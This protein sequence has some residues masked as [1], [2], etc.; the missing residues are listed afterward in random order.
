MLLADRQMPHLRDIQPTLQ[1]KGFAFAPPSCSLNLARRYAHLIDSFA[2]DNDVVTRLSYRSVIDLCTSLLAAIS[3]V[4]IHAKETLKILAKKNW[5]NK[6]SVQRPMTSAARHCPRARTRSV[7]P[8]PRRSSL[9]P[10]PSP[11]QH[12]RRYRRRDGQLIPLHERGSASS[13]TATAADDDPHRRSSESS[14]SSA[15]S[16]ASDRSQ[17]RMLIIERSDTEQFAGLSIK[18]GMFADHMPIAY[19]NALQA[20]LASEADSMSVDS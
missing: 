10:W 16:S 7:R 20:W 4:E 11:V 2:L 17:T 6:L 14:T 13:S 1:L 18:G 19:E 15:W 8:Q 9:V 5:I 12:A 3:Q